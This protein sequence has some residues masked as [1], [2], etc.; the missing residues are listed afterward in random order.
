[1][2]AILLLMLASA[3]RAYTSSRGVSSRARW[4][5]SATSSHEETENEE[6]QWDPW[7][8]PRVAERVQKR[9]RNNKSR[10]RQHVRRRLCG[11]H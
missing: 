7:N 4:L 10:F 11:A 8:N 2:Q 1:M 9:R 5:S 6:Q 3:V